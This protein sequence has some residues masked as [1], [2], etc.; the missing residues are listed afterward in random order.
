ME[1]FILYGLMMDSDQ[2]YW[3]DA[4]LR[5]RRS[6]EG[7]GLRLGVLEWLSCFFFPSIVTTNNKKM[8]EIFTFN[9]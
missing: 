6:A 8:F 5:E 9:T 1:G 4:C 3:W 7:G 2:N